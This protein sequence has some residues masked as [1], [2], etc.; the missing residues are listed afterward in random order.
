MLRRAP[1]VLASLLALTSACSD[2]AATCEPACRDG[3]ACVRGACVSA[4]NPACE[5]SERC[6]AD[7]RCV[8]ADLDAAESG[9]ANESRLDAAGLDAFLSSDD[10]GAIDASGATEDAPLIDAASSDAG[11]PRCDAG[12]RALWWRM[13]RAHGARDRCALSDDGHLWHRHVLRG[14]SR[15]RSV[16][17]HDGPR[18][19]AAGDALGQRRDLF[20]SSSRPRSQARPSDRSA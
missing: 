16:H 2:P 8:P 20:S 1:L 4:C 15:G 5:A 18:L 9:D 6:T 11:P 12:S 3:F 7:A 14:R 10:A 19:H 17:G 13:R